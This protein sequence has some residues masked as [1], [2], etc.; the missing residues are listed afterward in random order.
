MSSADPGGGGGAAAS[1]GSSQDMSNLQEQFSQ[2]QV[3]IWRNA[4][5]I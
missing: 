4:L 5:F 1:D 2:Q 3:R